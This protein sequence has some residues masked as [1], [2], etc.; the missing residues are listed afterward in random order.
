M[1]NYLVT[2]GA[3]FIGSHLT[4]RLVEDGHTVR[5]LDNFSTGKR[6]NLAAVPGHFELLEG[7]LRVPEDCR[8]AC[9]GIEVVFHIGA[10]PSVPKSIE[11]P[12]DCHDCNVNG[13]F[14]LLMAAVECK[15]RRVIYAASSSAYGDV[16][17]SPK[18]ETLRPEPK[19]PYAVQKLAGELYCRTFHE[20]FGLETFS[21]RYFNV[22]GPR[23]DPKSQYAAA[24]PAFIMA[25]LADQPPTIF[26]DGEQTRDFT[27]I[28]NVVHANVL[29][30]QADRLAGEAVNAACGRSISL[31]QII[32]QINK[33]TGKNIAPVYA[34]PR[35]GDVR[36]S[37]ADNRLAKELI[38]YDPLVDFDEG[39]ARTIEYYQTL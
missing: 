13:T 20:C 1:A 39:L 10:L 11:Q 22:F 8:E 24:I 2:G 26:G 23:Q 27:Y 17:V 16:E 14:N 28:D 38:G 33:V 7:D 12:Q 36:H 29:A 32:N 34:E 35:P 37:L 30:A 3:G 31:N 21:L 5:V 4:A 9:R 18:I 19:S 6:E 25:I 15:C